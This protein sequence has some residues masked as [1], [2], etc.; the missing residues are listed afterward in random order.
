MPSTYEVHDDI[1][2]LNRVAAGDQGAVGEL[3]DRYSRLL[4]G[5]VLRILN[6]RGEAE[7][8]LQEVFVQAWRGSHTY[9]AGLGSPAG[10]LLGIA[11]NR[12]IDRLRAGAT[13]LR[14]VDGTMAPRPVETPEILCSLTERQQHVHAALAAL[15]GEQREL[16]ERAY[17]DGS[18]QSEMAAQLSLPLGTV[19]TRVR[20]GLHTL[21]RLLEGR[22]S[23]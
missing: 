21:R 1:L 11:R 20:T 9:R 13:R 6:D 8:V 10:W 19:K 23:E 22:V 2:L 3:Y 7:E 4:F 16:I 5:L 18:T 15:P 14:A 17:F 12:A